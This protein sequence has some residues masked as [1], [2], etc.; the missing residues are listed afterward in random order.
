MD[1]MDVRLDSLA[2]VMNQARGAARVDAMAALLN[3]MIAH[4]R[5]MRREMHRGK[6]EHGMMPDCPRGG[7]SAADSGQTGGAQHQH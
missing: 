6:M 3:L 5:E 4:H 1:A 2:Q 7:K